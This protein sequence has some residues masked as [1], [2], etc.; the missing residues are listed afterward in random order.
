[1][2]KIL[3]PLGC[4]M[5]AFI[6][7]LG[8][9][10]SAEEAVRLQDD[11]YAVV[12]AE[13]LATTEIP[14][15]K[16]GVGSMENIQTDIEKLLMADAQ[17]LMAGEIGADDPLLTQVAKF[18]S[19]VTDHEKREADG[20]APLMPYLE[21][22]DALNSLAD[23][24]AVAAQ[25]MRGGMPAVLGFSVM[26]DMK[27]AQ[28]NALYLAGPNLILPD[29]TY[30]AAD[31]P[32][33]PALLGI[34]SDML[35]QL[36]ALI[37][38]D[39]A[40][41]AAIIEDTVAFDAL[42]VPLIPS[43]EESSDVETMYNP[44][45]FNDF[46]QM[47]GVFD[48]G[49]LIT[50][51][52]GQQP[53]KIIATQPKF[54]ESFPE[55]INE[56]NFPLMKS[57]LKTR[58]VMGVGAYLNRE[59]YET[60]LIYQ[61]TL[62]GQPEFSPQEEIDFKL[63][64]GLFDQVIGEYYGRTYLG[65]EAKQDVLGMVQNIIDVYKVRMEN[66]TWLSEETRAKAI[67]KLDGM[68]VQIGYPDELPAYYAQIEVDKNASL[69]DNSFALAEISNADDLSD[70]GKEVN[71]AI[72]P[73]G[74]ATVN[75]MYQPLANTITFPAAILQAPFYSLDR[76]A[77]ANYGGI[78]AVIAHE[79]SHA[80]DTNGAKF[81]E[82][83]NM[84]DWWTE[85]DYAKFEEL[86]EAMVV[87]FDGLEYA[88]GTVN[89]ILTKTE[90]IADAGGLSCTL[91]VVKSLPDGNLEDFFRNWATVWRSK[92]RTEV[93]QLKLN[94]DVHAPDKIRANIQVQ[95]F[96]EF[97]ETFGVTEGDGMW[98]APEDRVALW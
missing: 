59:Y 22:V 3:R 2:K 9:M 68:T 39:E 20:V 94:I 40:E 29:T 30:Y 84:V 79:I 47:G 10:A 67:R 19:I 27:D 50:E 33:G 65:E 38:V 69:L 80:F 18:F 63:G 81:D 36:Y 13:W 88:G 62:S 17:K 75:A 44:I 43:S 96:E 87:E 92:F 74:A 85:E 25:W 73:L 32:G 56:E 14:G 46:A 1:M 45:A 8:G 16:A 51:F 34:Y 98:R 61:M 23:Y 86:S 70:Y 37:G 97:F 89:G 66:N 83:G 57:W 5:L 72:W 82:F 52:L 76:S 48:L 31:H 64:A 24:Q 49:A 54:F 78:G 6:L 12:N 55:V 28:T 11:F 93:E 71:R 41:A 90:N 35:A 42:L 4:L 58:L 15:D 7:L 26:A 91:E 21:Q 60:S 53:D 95:N 77:S